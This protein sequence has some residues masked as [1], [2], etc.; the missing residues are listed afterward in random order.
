MKSMMQSVLMKFIEKDNVLSALC[1]LCRKSLKLFRR[2]L[3]GLRPPLG[4]FQNGSGAW[5]VFL[6]DY[7]IIMSCISFFSSEPFIP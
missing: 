2:I 5:K 1:D 7:V 6:F 4:Q 3:A